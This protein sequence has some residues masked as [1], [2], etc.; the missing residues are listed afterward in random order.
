VDACFAKLDAMLP[1]SNDRDTF[2]FASAGRDADAPAAGG[3]MH[4][5]RGRWLSV[6]DSPTTPVTARVAE[7]EALS[8]PS[9]VQ[10]SRRGTDAL[11]P[12]SD[13]SADDVALHVALD[14][15]RCDSVPSKLR[16]WSGTSDGDGRDNGALLLAFAVLLL[17]GSGLLACGV[18]VG[19]STW[20]IT[21]SSRVALIGGGAVVGV[22]LFSIAALVTRPCRGRP[23]WPQSRCRSVA[24]SLLAAVAAVVVAGCIADFARREVSLGWGSDRVGAVCVVVAIVVVVC[25]ALAAWIAVQRL[26]RFERRESLSPTPFARGVCVAMDW[27]CVVAV[28]FLY[29]V[30]LAALAFVVV[31]FGLKVSA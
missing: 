21:P 22:S 28:C 12:R 13:V 18:V 31:H 17:L 10:L 5:G 23:F 27:A 29:L 3:R 16:G 26:R 30:V 20:S 4:G 1:V 9:P 11:S 7:V 14:T 6:V 24:L 15:P 25:A 2:F 8:M 19:A